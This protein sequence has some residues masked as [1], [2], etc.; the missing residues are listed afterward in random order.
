MPRSNEDQA[1]ASTPGDPRV[2]VSDELIAGSVLSV[3]GLAC[4]LALVFLFD[5]V[6]GWIPVAV[7]LGSLIVGGVTIAL[8]RFRRSNP[9][10]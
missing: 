6:W 2:D 5:T 4:G 9:D 10:S 1:P 8:I 3:V 7:G